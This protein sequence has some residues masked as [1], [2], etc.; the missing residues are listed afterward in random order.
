MWGYLLITGEIRMVCHKNK[1][2]DMTLQEAIQERHSIRTYRNEPLSEDVEKVLRE[3]VEEY[4]RLGNLHIQ[5]VTGETKAFSGLLSYGVFKGVCNYLVMAGPRSEDLDERIGYYGERLVLLAQ[6]L[7]LNSCWVGLNYRK[8]DAFKLESNDKL[9]CVIALGYGEGTP[10]QH[11]VRSLEEL[12]NVSDLSPKWF[13]RGVE[14]AQLAPTA[15]N[16][17]R[18]YFEYQGSQGTGK[19]VVAA[20]RTFSV[21]GYTKVD[22]GIVK[23]HFEIAAGK[24]NFVWA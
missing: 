16:Q 8:T 18:F 17:Q 23:C 20:R 15:V 13:R 6:M 24:E 3:S 11:K 21:F 14:A 2:I 4:N 19:P 22:L 5:L 7:G 1:D 10:R 12:S 9:I